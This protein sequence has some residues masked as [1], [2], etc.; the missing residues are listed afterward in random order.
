MS[1]DPE[2]ER[3]V[4]QCVDEVLGTLGEHGAGTFISSLERNFDLKKT[5]I[6][7]KPEVFSKGLY[8]IFGE[9]AAD[10]LETAIAQ[11]LLTSLGIDPRTTPTL[12][13]AIVIAK[14]ANERKKSC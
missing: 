10:A 9:E 11:K 2:I 13:G 6:A 7:R 12:A 3:R 1:I 14:E 5:E 8:L 4:L